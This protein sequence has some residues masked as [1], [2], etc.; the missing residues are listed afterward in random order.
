MNHRLLLLPLAALALVGCVPALLNPSYIV[1]VDNRGCLT[2]AT[3]FIDNQ[4]VGTAG[5]AGTAQFTVTRG[6][7]TINVDNDG[8]TGNLPLAVFSDTVWRN[9]RCLI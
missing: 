5:L 6:N 3:V 8:L 2:P 4:K 9:S 7:H 1:T